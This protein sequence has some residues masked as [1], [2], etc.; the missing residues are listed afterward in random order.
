MRG[1]R[2]ALREAQI[3]MP[4]CLQAQSAASAVSGVD[5]LVAQRAA[6]EADIALTKLHL[7]MA[8]VRAPFDGQSF[9]SKPPSGNLLLPCAYFLP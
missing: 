9:P 5:A 8:T 7:E 6:V 1:P 3:L 4:Y 2:S